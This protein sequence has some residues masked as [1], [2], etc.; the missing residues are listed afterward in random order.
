MTLRVAAMQINCRMLDLKGNSRKVIAAYRQL[1]ASGAHVVTAPEL[2]LT[3]YPAVDY[4]TNAAV[5]REQDKALERVLRAVGETVLVLTH[6]TRNL[7]TGKPL[8]NTIVV[9]QHGRIIHRQHKACLADQSEFMEWRQFEPN[10]SR[11]EAFQV[12]FADGETARCAVLACEDIWGGPVPGGSG[13][14]H[15]REAVEEVAALRVEYLFVPNGSP[16]W[17]NKP[18]LRDRLL[19]HVATRTG[20]TVVYANKTGG[21]D[22]LVF[23]G[24]SSIYAPHGCV[25]RGLLFEEGVVT[26]YCYGIADPLAVPVQDSMEYLYRLLVMSVRDYYEKN[27]YF[28]GLLVSSSGGIDSALTA[29]LGVE[30]LGP[31]RMRLLMQPSA[32]S[33]EH[34][35]QDAV[36]LARN[37]GVEQNHLISIEPAMNALESMLE[38]YFVGLPRDVTEEN[39]Q[40][41]IRG[42]VAMAFANKFHLLP[43]ATGNKSEM[44]VGYATLYGD[45]CGGYAVLKD[46]YKTT[47][48]KLARYVNERAGHALIPEHILT[49]PPSAELSEGQMDTDSL[50][51]Y[52]VLDAILQRVIEEGLFAAD[53]IAQ[54]FDAET[55]CRVERMVTAAEFKRRQAPPGPKTTAR[56]LVADTGRVV[57]IT[58]NFTRIDD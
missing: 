45:M 1:A 18:L 47:V 2:V 24:D 46:V 11:I 37:L 23:D 44:S 9:M 40:A 14:I 28:T 53:I 38:P 31:D 39:E 33:S 4:Y 52:D 36:A 12:S 13:T 27:P 32:I 58:V 25:A 41:R 10:P 15:T 35:V 19:R 49:K 20:A 42:V 43:L 51:P 54:G 7:G 48:F 21:T 26:N 5:L 16:G 3:D 6:V 50:P 30:A 57:P 55:V 56:G 34:S 17:V 22:N 8:F 29:A